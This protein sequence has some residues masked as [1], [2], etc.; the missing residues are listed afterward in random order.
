M[1]SPAVCVGLRATKVRSVGPRLLASKRHAST[2]S[3]T[4][5][6]MGNP[7]VRAGVNVASCAWL[8]MTALIVF[9][10]LTFTGPFAKP[11]SDMVFGFWLILTWRFV[12]R[13]LYRR[14]WW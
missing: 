6:F 14:G 9:D 13:P 10:F 5:K 1:A 3:E 8:A 12:L 4:T 7:F 11:G 2:F